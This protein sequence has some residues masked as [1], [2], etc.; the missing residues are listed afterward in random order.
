MLVFFQIYSP[1]IIVSLLPVSAFALLFL[2]LRLLLIVVDHFLLMFI[3]MFILFFL[4]FLLFLLPLC[5]FFAA[6]LQSVG[7]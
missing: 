1:F 4:L 7:R 5:Y 2:L 3:L 6:W